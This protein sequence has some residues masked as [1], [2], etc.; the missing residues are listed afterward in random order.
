MDSSYLLILAILL[1]SLAATVPVFMALFFTG[2]FGLVYLLG[3]DPQIVIEVL[4][5]SM[6]KFALVVVMFFVLCGNIMTTGSIVEKLIKTA[7]VLVG[8]LPGGLAMAGIL[9]CGFFGAISGSTVATVVAI[10]GFMIPAL[11]ENDYD[12][13]F[14]VG[15]MTTAPI[16]GVVIPPSI[17]MILY[18][19]VSN[20]P[21]EE[22]F[23]T[24]F[25]PGLMIMGAMSLYAYLVC[26][27]KG[28]KTIHR[29]NLKEALPVIRE[30]IW[31]LFLPVLIF[32]GIYSGMFTANEAAVVACFYAFF[33]EIFIHRDMKLLDVKR[34]IVS[35]AV[36]SATLLIIVAGASVFGEYL[37]FE[38]IPNKIATA[39]VSS[40]SSPWVF[41]LAVNI[42]LLIIGMFM[43]IIS[44][45]LILTP[46]FLPLL[47]K[48]GINTMHFGLL[49]TINLG[50]GYCTPPLGVSLYISGA[51]V[52]R[53]LVYV[54]KAVMPFLL[55]QIAILLILTFFPD[56]VLFLPRW[57][58]G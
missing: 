33:V 15:V 44:A 28:L 13:K 31:A 27:K 53:D 48:F 2:T 35:S 39:V 25:V 11:V 41:L 37:T 21:L 32:G 29:P 40:I 6:D 56:L 58:Y 7:N 9:A 38:Q 55:I 23:L 51:T 24:G 50:I 34:V 52:N 36:T 46:I 5:R 20:D 4:Y 12:E 45:T 30:S 18:A 14:S 3:I 42:L 10:G 54:S 22:L 47:N 1:G 43:D 49:M 19:M 57:V 26:K 16:L 8:F 17:A